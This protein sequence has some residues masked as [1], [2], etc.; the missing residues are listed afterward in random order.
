MGRDEVVSDMLTST[1]ED[2]KALTAQE[3]IFSLIFNF[4]TIRFDATHDI[5]DN[6]FK[7]EKIQKTL[8]LFREWFYV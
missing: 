5:I 4:L 7:E 2:P 8:I 6:I 1:F 3:A